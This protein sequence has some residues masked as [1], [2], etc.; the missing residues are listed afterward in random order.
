MQ[1][2]DPRL[3][4]EVGDLVYVRLIQVLNFYARRDVYYGRATP[5]DLQPSGDDRTQSCL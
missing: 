4:E 5:H 2:A 3:L 1:P